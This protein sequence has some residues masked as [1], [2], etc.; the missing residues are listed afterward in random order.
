M[1]TYSAHPSVAFTT[2]TTLPLPPTPPLH[3]LSPSLSQ[4]KSASAQAYS[5]N[6][7]GLFD[8]CFSLASTQQRK[9]KDIPEGGSKGII[10]LSLAHQ[11][12]GK[13]G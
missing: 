10:L 4:V 8:E 1:C 7:G 2:T 6:L 11:D 3:S 13:V 9:N 5:T 12:K